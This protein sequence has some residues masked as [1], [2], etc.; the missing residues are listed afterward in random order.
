MAGVAL[1][2]FAEMQRRGVVPDAVTYGAVISACEKGQ[3]LEKALEH[4]DAMMERGIVPEPAT[5]AVL[6]SMCEK[7]ERP[8]DAVRA[9]EAALRRGLLSD[10]A[11]R[12][13]VADA[14]ERLGQPGAALEI[15][16]G[17]QA[18]PSSSS[19]PWM[20]RPAGGVFA[21]KKQALRATRR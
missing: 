12:E 5:V 9:F 10:A 2:H 7:E 6:V 8:A 17:K 15:L 3:L 20:A 19:R 13:K 4:F 18:S 11:L 14:Y 1:E 16:G 21:E